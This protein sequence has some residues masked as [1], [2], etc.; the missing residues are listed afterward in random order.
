MHMSKIPASL[1]EEIDRIVR[2]FIWGHKVGTRKLH[3]IRLE[4]LT[5]LVEDGKLGIRAM[6]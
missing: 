2:C 1:L 4:T 6:R 3:L 5:K